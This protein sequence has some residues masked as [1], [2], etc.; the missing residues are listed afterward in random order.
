MNSYRNVANEYG[1]QDL[2]KW[3]V[4]AWWVGYGLLIADVRWAE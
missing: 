1:T 4:C 2:R 3:A